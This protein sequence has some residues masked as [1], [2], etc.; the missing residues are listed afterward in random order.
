MKT[1]IEPFRIKVIEPIKMTSVAERKLLLEGAGFNLF[2]LNAEDV[3][4][5]LLTDSG[6]SAMSAAQWSALVK[7]DEA[8]A[9]AASFHR[10]KESAQRLFGFPHILP[11]HQGRAA[12]RIFFDV[13][14]KV[15]DIVPN[16][17]HFD[18][19]RAN[20]ERLG[21]TAVDL[22]AM[23][24]SEFQGNISLSGLERLLAEHAD[25]VP[26]GMITLTNNSNAGQPASM[27]NIAAAS[28]IL[29][30]Y[31]K[32]LIVDAARCV[33][34]AY[35]I[36]MRE[37][38]YAD[39]SIPAIVRQIM[40]YSQGCLMSAKKDGMANIGGLIG[41]FD[42]ALFEKLK[43]NSIV[44][45][46]FPT[47]GGLSGRD[48]DAIAT[49]FDEVVSQDYLD[50]RWQTA[51]Y[52]VESLLRAGVPVVTPPAMH[53]VY[54]YAGR[55]LPH[56]RAD[57]L[58]G[59]SLACALYEEAGIRSCEIGT[60]MFGQHATSE[61]I[62]LSLP[63]RV[64]TKAHYDYVIEAITNV[65]ERA[66]QLAPMRISKNADAPLRHFI[67]EFEYVLHQTGME[68]FAPVETAR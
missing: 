39:F 17:T 44:T 4:I 68:S 2:K 43:I 10:F 3:I 42:D 49:G 15:G 52:I 46:G 24:D 27:S 62:R 8:Y 7:A 65:Y 16:N 20:I 64:Y 18:T 54:L 67:A 12:E 48:L 51:S 31:G 61:L 26:F 55:F 37:R 60:V 11:V 66:A 36:K 38:A 13:M 1:R 14:V 5:D 32:P 41:L 59:Q 29:R 47:Y 58:P 50:Y 21:A 53:A 33:E 40:S 23:D 22:P 6:T 45:E 57:Q 35:F 28:A 34:N 9:G 19:T 56:L 30:R 63:R 25:R